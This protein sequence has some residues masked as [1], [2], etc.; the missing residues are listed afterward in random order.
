ML[1]VLKIHVTMS[2][3]GSTPKLKQKALKQK[4][5]MLFE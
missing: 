1:R 3:L 2:F 4:D 5:S